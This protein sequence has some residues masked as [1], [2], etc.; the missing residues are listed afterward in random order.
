MMDANMIEL[1][2]GSPVLVVPGRGGSGPDPRA[3]H[4]LARSLLR[5]LTASGLDARD[6]LKLAAELVDQVA[7]HKAARRAHRPRAK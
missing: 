6:V 2:E 1:K 7:E 4:I 5:D 3:V